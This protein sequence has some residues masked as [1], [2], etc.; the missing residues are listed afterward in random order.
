VS[1][2]EP[3]TLLIDKL[4][5]GDHRAAQALWEQYF[6]QLVALAR[7]RL[8]ATARRVADEEDVALSAFDSFCRA[9]EHGRFPDL[10]D[11]DNLW[12]LL[13]T[14]TTRKAADLA[15]YDQAQ[16]RGG[17]QVRGDSAVA[18]PAGEDSAAGFDAL[19]GQ[20]RT[21]DMAAQL[22][23]EFQRLLQRLDDPADPHLRDIAVWKMQG[24]SNAE[25]AAKLGCSIPTVER[26]LRLIRT[27]FKDA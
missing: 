4:R 10:K 23:E 12:A 11:G 6:P 22:A 3:V 13:V 21:P 7:A 16:K 18:P 17:G 1:S 25:I 27:V 26:R 19:A 15:Q 20:D 24:H 14:I 9:A 5:A 2:P 8:R